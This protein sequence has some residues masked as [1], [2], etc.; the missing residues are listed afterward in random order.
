MRIL[1]VC[2]GNICRSPAAEAAIR[3][4]A[5]EA[6]LEVEVDSAGT[7]SWHIGEPPHPEMVTAGARAGLV[8]AGRARKVTP[9]DFDR[10]DVILAMD[11][12]NLRHLLALAPSKEAQAK[13]RLFRTY[14][15]TSDEEDVPDPWGGP[16]EGYE[17]TLRIVE[18][19]ARGL[20]DS[21]TSARAE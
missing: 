17:E 2:L 6:G 16:T 13:V 1:A 19:A 14:D 20:V 21:L 9:A 11:R 5:A 8:V 7:G 18:T 15:Q 3:R 12:S 4:A 10:Y